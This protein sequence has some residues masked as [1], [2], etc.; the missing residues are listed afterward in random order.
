[1]N[2]F[3]LS[4]KGSTLSAVILTK[5]PEHFLALRRHASLKT[6]GRP[7]VLEETPLVAEQRGLSFNS[8]FDP[9]SHGLS[10]FLSHMGVR[11]CQF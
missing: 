2:S 3:I 1:M 9:T 8:A 11:L 6:T 5:L 4:R 10:F 7:L